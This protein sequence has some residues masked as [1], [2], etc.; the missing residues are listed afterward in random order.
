[1]PLLQ[2]WKTAKTNFETATRKGKPSKT[3]MG[4]IPKAS[5]IESSLK[6]FESATSSDAQ[7]KARKKFNDAAATYLKFLDKVKHDESVAVGGQDQYG[8]EVGNL[9]T[10]LG[11][12]RQGVANVAEYPRT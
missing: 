11:I 3:I 4:V 1:M 7:K 9:I 10:A 2:D 8:K 6:D 5:G 12:I